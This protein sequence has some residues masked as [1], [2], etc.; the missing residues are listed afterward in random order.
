MNNATSLEEMSQ[1]IQPV[2]TH[3]KITDE[4]LDLDE[5]RSN[6][7]DSLSQLTEQMKSHAQKDGDFDEEKV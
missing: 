3:A 4:G 1:A 2:I 5:L 6:M 7:S